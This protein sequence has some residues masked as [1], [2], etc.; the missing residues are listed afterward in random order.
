MSD[1]GD[2]MKITKSKI[3][4]YCIKLPKL[5]GWAK[6]SISDDGTVGIV[7]DYGNWGYV[8]THHGC[9]SI[10]HFLVSIDS[11]YAWNKFSGKTKLNSHKTI[12]AMK[13]EINSENDPDK[14]QTMLSYLGDLDGL[15]SIDD[16]YN[17]FYYTDNEL[18]EFFDP[19]YLP[20][21]ED[22]DPQFIMFFERLWQPL[23]AELKSEIKHSN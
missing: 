12:A 23:M 16:I 17:Y 10:K 3:D 13:K 4:E 15:S 21:V 2:R 11:W 1:L 7:S 14:V 5:G 6:V 8:W 9:E 20:F 22:K 19:C 18:T